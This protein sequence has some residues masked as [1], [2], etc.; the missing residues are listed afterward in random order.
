MAEENTARDVYRYTSAEELRANPE[1]ILSMVTDFKLNKLPRLQNLKRYLE[2]DNPSVTDTNRRNEDGVSDVRASHAF[3]SYIVTFM[4]GY[5]TGNPIHLDYDDEA[6]QEILD[7]VNKMNNADYQNSLL[8]RDASTYGWAYEIH[9]RKE[10]G[11]H[12]KRADVMN[13]FAIYNMTIER[14]RIGA[15]RFYDNPFTESE[16]VEFYDDRGKLTYIV[17]G[18]DLV[19]ESEEPHTYGSVPINELENNDERMGDFERVTPQMDLYDFAQSDTANYMQDFND[20]ILALFG[21]IDLGHG[22]TEDEKIEVLREMRRARMLL[23]TPPK[24][25]DG[26]EGSI[27]A[28][29]LTK[30][31]DVAGTEAYKKRIV[32]DIHKLSFTPDLTDEKFAGAQSGKALEH[33][34]FGLEVI[35]S[36]KENA[37]KAFLQER[38]RLIMNIG[39]V[40]SE[41]GEFDPNL[42]DINI[43]NKVPN[44]LSDAIENFNL[45]GGEM[46]NETKLRITKVVDNPILEQERLDEEIE[47]EP[48]LFDQQLFGGL[49]NDGADTSVG[50]PEEPERGILE[51]A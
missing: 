22:L 15:V 29:Y 34:L 20:A 2:N 38:Y 33:K 18:T 17:E 1:V 5:M 24:T 44:S 40:A 4:Q 13:T 19:L 37:L 51:E 7:T 31:Y 36:N 47:N 39:Q 11:S 6:V 45:L 26:R 23:L 25:L 30:Q 50:E 49:M 28:E 9:Y 10:D 21:D 42:L 32:N 8:E 35:E 27:H 46:T 3:A 43:V 12:F 41:N 48:R 16:Y 14:E